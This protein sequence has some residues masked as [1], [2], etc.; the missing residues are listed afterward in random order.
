MRP[1]V[2]GTLV[3]LTTT[4]LNSCSKEVPP[5]ARGLVVEA[6]VEGKRTSIDGWSDCWQSEGNGN[7]LV[8]AWEG[9]RNDNGPSLYVSYVADSQ[10]V[11]QI[12]LHTIDVDYQSQKPVGL[13]AK[14]LGRT[15]K[16]SSPDDSVEITVTCPS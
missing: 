5:P 8:Q 6:T 4:A 3:V 11:N 2:V 12:E 10:M 9:S 16:I 7:M 13:T 15:M 14:K 1:L